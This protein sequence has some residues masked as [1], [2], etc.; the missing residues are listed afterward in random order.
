MLASLPPGQVV[1]LD[2]KEMQLCLRTS[3]REN[4]IHHHDWHCNDYQ[5]PG[6]LLKC[7]P[8]S[9]CIPIVNQKTKV[10]PK[11]LP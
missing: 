2:E 11:V 7:A 6:M 4:V 9:R 1:P 5:H 10:S 8:T 3:A